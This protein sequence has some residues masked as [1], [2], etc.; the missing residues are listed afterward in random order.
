MFQRKKNPYSMI[1]RIQ[2]MF[3]AAVAMICEL[4]LYL[5]LTWFFLTHILMTTNETEYSSCIRVEDL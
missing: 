3:I 4:S 5:L 1:A 2:G